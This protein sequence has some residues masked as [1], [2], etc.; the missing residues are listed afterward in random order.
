MAGAGEESASYVSCMGAVTVD[1]AVYKAV[2]VADEL[3]AHV[4]RAYGD[5]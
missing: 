2:A 5:V 3:E 1:G 4:L